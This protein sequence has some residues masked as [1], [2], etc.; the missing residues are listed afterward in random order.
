MK[1]PGW[2][3]KYQG[4]ER[5]LVWDNSSTLADILSDTSWIKIG[6]AEESRKTN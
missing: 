2:K 3:T 5:E 4:S 6:L 1:A